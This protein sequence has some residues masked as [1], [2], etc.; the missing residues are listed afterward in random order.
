MAWYFVPIAVFGI[1]AVSPLLLIPLVEEKLA[2][3]WSRGWEEP[4]DRQVFAYRLIAWPMY[5]ACLV[6]VFLYGNDLL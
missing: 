5:L 3:E 2:Y 4:C 1:L 6:L